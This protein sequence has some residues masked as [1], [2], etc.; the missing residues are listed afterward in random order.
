M[1]AFFAISTLV[2][3]SSCSSTSN[4]VPGVDGMHKVSIRGEDAKDTESAGHKE[5][6]SYCKDQKKQVE[7]L[8]DDTVKATS[9]EINVEAFKKAE[10]VATD[11]RFKCI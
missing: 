2:V 9:A 11:I 7:F 10:A 1:R 4:V 3:L 6:R 5:A 8:S